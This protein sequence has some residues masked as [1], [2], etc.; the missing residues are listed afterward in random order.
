[1]TNKTKYD[2]TN[3]WDQELLL[4]RVTDLLQ[5]AGL[6]YKQTAFHSPPGEPYRLEVIFTT[7]NL[8]GE[9]NDVSRR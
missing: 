5:D 7:G 2:L 6:A 9:R 4:E 8:F 3:F 1:M